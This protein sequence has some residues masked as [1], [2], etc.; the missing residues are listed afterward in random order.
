[1]RF[2][3][4]AQI[5]Q[6]GI[7]AAFDAATDQ[8]LSDD[9]PAPP[10]AQVDLYARVGVWPSEARCRRRAPAP[11]VIQTAKLRPRR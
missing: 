7:G 1:M 10:I 6:T 11:S 5:E 2:Q 4:T 9:E 8:Q 3:L